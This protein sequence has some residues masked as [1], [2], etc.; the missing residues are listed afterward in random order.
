[1][2]V[3]YYI[4]N[5]R[6]RFTLLCPGL[7]GQTAALLRQGF[8]GQADPPFLQQADRQLDQS[9]DDDEDAKAHHIMRLLARTLPPPGRR[10]DDGEDAHD[11]A[12]KRIRK[13]Q[14]ADECPRPPRP[15]IQVAQQQ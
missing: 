6:R 4:T 5:C 12:D 9:K 2:F 15:E 11:I 10:D 13:T 7:R 14:Q 8:E 1:M 3:T